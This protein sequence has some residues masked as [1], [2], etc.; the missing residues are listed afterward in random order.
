M[1]AFRSR[2]IPSGE[3]RHPHHGRLNILDKRNV[4]GDV[5][6][7]KSTD[8]ARMRK[9]TVSTSRPNRNANYGKIS[10]QLPERRVSSRLLLPLGQA[11]FLSCH[12]EPQ[13]AEPEGGSSTL[14]EPGGDAEQVSEEEARLAAIEESRRKLAELE[15]DR[16]IWEEQARKRQQEEQRQAQEKQ[17]QAQK[18]RVEQERQQAA[19]AEQ[20][21][22]QTEA[23][24]QAKTQARA[25][26]MQLQQALEQRWA[27]ERLQ[28]ANK[29]WNDCL[30]LRRYVDLTTSFDDA[31]FTLAPPD[32]FTI[33]WPILESP[34]NLTFDNI[35]WQAVEKFFNAAKKLLSPDDFRRFVHQASMRFHPDRWHSRGVTSRVR[36]D[37]FRAGLERACVRVCQGISPFWQELRKAS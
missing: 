22:R 20:E 8:D 6:W 9:R 13:T 30:A 32:F 29:P 31:K 5:V 36:E 18:R 7:I 21:R 15:R 19:A 24:A 34:A 37:E 3:E 12:L 28:W 25:A 23:A 17:Q 1:N 4:S 27:H 14:S 35:T 33:P 11:V 10:S 26:Q 16:P 2:P